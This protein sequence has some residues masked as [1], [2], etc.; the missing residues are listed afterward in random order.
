MHLKEKVSLHI[1]TLLPVKKITHRTRRQHRHRAR[2]CSP[3]KTPICRQ[4]RN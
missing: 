4:P 1:R 2:K 3:D